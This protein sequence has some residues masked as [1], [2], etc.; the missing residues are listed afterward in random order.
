MQQF[1]VSPISMIQSFWRNR[2]LIKSMIV[3]EVVGKY[4]GSLMGIAWSFF[5]PLIML[6]VYTFVFSVVFKARW[7]IDSGGNKINFALLLFIGLIIH[8]L[9]AECVD[10]SPELIVSNATYVKNVIFPLEI[11]PLVSF[12]TALFH[13]SISLVVLLCA[14]IFIFHEVVWTVIFIPFILLPVALSSIGLTWFISALGVYVR[15]IKQIT[16]V[17]T[18]VLL[19]ISAVFYPINALPDKYQIW[20]KINP[21]ALLIEQGRNAMIVGRLPDFIQLALSTFGGFLIACAGFA[22]FQKTRRGFA[23]VL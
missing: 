22:W 5:N 10:R 1:S 19:F 8:G 18:T 14:Q 12:G 9:F 21:L 2:Q 13:F 3:R 15:D 6:S 11:I 7:T 17:F 16:G 20:I 23:D 4:R